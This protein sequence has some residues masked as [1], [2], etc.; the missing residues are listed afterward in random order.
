MTARTQLQLFQRGVDAE[1]SRSFE[2]V[3]VRDP[4]LPSQL[5]CLS[6]TAELEMIESSRLFLVHHPGYR[7]IQQRR[8][9]DRLTLLQSGAVHLDFG[10]EVETV[11]I[12]D[13][14]LQEAKGLAGFGGPVGH[15]IVDLGGAKGGAAQGGLDDN[16]A[17]INS[18]RREEPP[19]QSLRRTPT[20]DNKTTFYRSLR[21]VQQRF[22]E[23]QDAW[24]ARKAGEIQ[25]YAD[26]SE[27]RNFFPAIEAVH[28]P[29][30]KTTAPLLS[31]D[32]STPLTEKI[33]ILQRWAEHFR[34][35]HHLRRRY[36]P[37][38]SSGDQH[39]PRSHAPFAR[40]H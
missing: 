23:M 24:T 6:K 37:S 8:Q 9:Y 17:A 2:Y 27:W 1:D 36:R 20:D 34:G 32:G 10:V 13:Y 18:A 16:D 3:C 38:A 12:P 31:V 39:R 30:T 35:V 40:N 25:R 5:Q 4:V 14:V 22:R 15:F 28:G 26:R 11:A 19:V 7:S 21:L 33:Q 29:S